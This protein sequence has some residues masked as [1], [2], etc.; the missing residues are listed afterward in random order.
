MFSRLYI[1][2]SLVFVVS[3]WFDWQW[4]EVGL[5]HESFRK[6]RLSILLVVGLLPAMWLDTIVKCGWRSLRVLPR[7][8]MIFSRCR[9]TRILLVFLV[10]NLVNW[11]NPLFQMSIF[12]RIENIIVVAFA[13]GLLCLQPPYALLLGESN[14]VTGRVL[15]TVGLELYPLRVVALL[16]NSRTG[17]SLGS[18]SV[19]TDDLRTASDQEWK[20]LVEQLA[21]IVQLIVLDARTDSP[22]VLEEVGLL[23]CRPE[24]LS[25]TL[26]IAG[27]K[28]ESPSGFTQ[29]LSSRS[30]SMRT[31]C[32]E[33]L[34]KAKP[35]ASVAHP[36]T[37]PVEER[38]KRAYQTFGRSIP[39]VVICTI[40][41][42]LG[43]KSD[44]GELT[45]IYIWVFV[46][47]CSVNA[48]IGSMFFV[49]QL[50]D[51]IAY[52]VVTDEEWFE[53]RKKDPLSANLL[54]KTTALIP[55]ALYL[56]LW[57]APGIWIV[58]ML[59]R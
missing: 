33:E 9:R 11:L 54:W 16:D 22:L 18:F 38:K 26:V 57:A 52:F 13:I 29:S 41:S 46:V 4:W 30:I 56:T 15:K 5:D 32:E 39:I 48:M 24:R 21:D 47:F 35:I 37:L 58:I 12:Q 3:I 34:T 43:L 51:I 1:L 2:T 55:A 50:L 8:A 10:L 14:T 42:S 27:P 25:R 6:L 7:M 17:S 53:A 59:S 36:L 23:E 28:G 20:M 44:G 45:Q 31:V 40:L 49:I 19:F